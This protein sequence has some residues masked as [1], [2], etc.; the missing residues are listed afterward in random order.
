MLYR[1]IGREF[2]KN[3]G[4]KKPNEQASRRKTETSKAIKA[5]RGTERSFVTKISYYR[6]EEARCTN[7]K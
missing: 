4:Q 7:K 1:D 5:A 6:E 2:Q 3:T